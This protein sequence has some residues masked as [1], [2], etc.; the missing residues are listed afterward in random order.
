[1]GL[2][3]VVIA[4]TVIA[5]LLIAG[6]AGLAYWHGVQKKLQ[7]TASTPKSGFDMDFGGDRKSAV[8]VPKG[9]KRLETQ[10]F[11][12]SFVMPDKW[13]AAEQYKGLRNG[14][15][16]AVTVGSSKD[17]KDKMIMMVVT[18]GLDAYAKQAERLYKEFSTGVTTKMEKGTWYGYDARRVTIHSK[19]PHDAVT[20]FVRIGNYTYQ[21]PDAGSYQS[22]VIAGKFNA[23][24]YKQFVESIRVK[25]P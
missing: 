14:T 10:Q 17:F 25:K 8:L 5:I 11:G 21:L 15:V 9:W 23:A 3:M 12:V 4:M 19:D 22:N 18:T 20:L 1:M 6:G 13:V 7:V 24:D 2:D 16:G